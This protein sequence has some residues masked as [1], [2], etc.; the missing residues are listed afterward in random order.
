MQSKG[1]N[2]AEFRLM[3]LATAQHGVL[4]LPQ[5]RAAGLGDGAVKH[6]VRSGRLH[7]IHRGVYAVGHAGL[8]DHGRWMAAVLACAPERGETER[9]AVLSHR[10]A[11]A[12]W[13]LLPSS[14]AAVDVTLLGGGGRKPRQGIRIHRTISLT[15]E[16][17]TLRH[18]IPVTNPMR[19]LLDLRSCLSLP[20]LNRA[21]RQ[22]EVLGYPI[23]DAVTGKDDPARSELERRFLRLC[24]RHRLPAPEVNVTVPTTRGSAGGGPSAYVADFLWREA[25]LIV[26]TDGYRYHRGR[27]TFERDRRRQTDLAAA[28]YEVLRFTWRQVVHEPQRVAAALRARL[29]TPLFDFAPP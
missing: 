22:A 2:A 20:L 6:R 9:P 17:T 26:E 21:R 12:L 23:D 8:S 27:A 24:R 3:R 18:G 10:S 16:D 5:L 29:V 7:R 14:P 11:G 28:G 13:R 25:R 4:S 1:A 19:T 15:A